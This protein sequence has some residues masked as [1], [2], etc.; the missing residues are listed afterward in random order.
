M[1]STKYE[2]V[3]PSILSESLLLETR[4]RLADPREPSEGERVSKT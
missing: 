1:Q 2:R 4:G 3:A